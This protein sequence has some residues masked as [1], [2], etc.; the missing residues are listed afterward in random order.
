MLRIAD[1]LTLFRMRKRL[2]YSKF[3]I[4]TFFLLAVDLAYGAFTGNSDNNKDK[5]SLKSLNSVDKLYTLSS[6]RSNT[7]RYKGSF[8]LFQQNNGNQLQVQSMIRMERGN[9]TYVYPYKY[10]VKVP[11]FVTPVAPKIR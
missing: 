8:D 2:I 1:N 7:F 11:R 3:F 4:A 9:T 5:F 6:L 10:S